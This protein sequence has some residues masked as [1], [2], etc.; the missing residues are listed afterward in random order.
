MSTHRVLRTAPIALLLLL[1]VRALPAQVPDSN[2]VALGIVTMAKAGH[3]VREDRTG[4]VYGESGPF[5]G[6]GGEVRMFF[7]DVWS[8]S[9]VIEYMPKSNDGPVHESTTAGAEFDLFLNRRGPVRLYLGALGGAEVTVYH[10]PAGG[11]S[12]IQ[13]TRLLIGPVAGGLLR[14]TSHLQLGIG[15]EYRFGTTP[16]IH[17]FTDA[18]GK[19]VPI[20]TPGRLVA[21]HV[22]CG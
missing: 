17:E 10:D 16:Y 8:A 2:T 4:K 5:V 9:F 21:R 11:G 22:C 12:P 18:D 13:T 7:R 6:V 15:A 14:C 19:T 3:L 1:A 20:R